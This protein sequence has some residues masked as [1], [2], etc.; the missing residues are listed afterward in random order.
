M[1]ESCRE[2]P[3]IGVKQKEFGIVSY[4][5]SVVIYAGIRTKALSKLC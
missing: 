5:R 4:V 2:T 3:Q 1:S